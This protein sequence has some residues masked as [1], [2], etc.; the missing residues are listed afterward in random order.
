MSAAICGNSSGKNPDIA[1]RI[2]ATLADLARCSLRDIRA[3]LTREIEVSSRR[4]ASASSSGCE[5][6]WRF[7]AVG[8]GLD[9][10]QPMETHDRRITDHTDGDVLVGQRAIMYLTKGQDHDT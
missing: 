7:L 9:L 8:E 4:P 2:R 10:T 6:G 3:W 5:D 1:S